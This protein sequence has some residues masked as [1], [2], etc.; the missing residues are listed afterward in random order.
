EIKKP[1]V[2]EEVKPKPEVEQP[3]YKSD[4]DV[5]TKGKPKAKET[6]VKKLSKTVKDEE[7]KIDIIPGEYKPKQ[8]ITFESI[9]TPKVTKHKETIVVHKTTPEE[10]PKE[11]DIP[12]KPTFEI[13]KHDKKVAKIIGPKPYQTTQI[14]F[15]STDTKPMQA[16][17]SQT[18]TQSTIT[19]QT[20]QIVH[21]E[22]RVTQSTFETRET[23]PQTAQFGVQQITFERKKPEEIK[24]E[25]VD[26]KL[27][28]VI[29]GEQPKTSQAEIS[30]FTQVQLQQATLEQRKPEEIKPEFVEYSLKKFTVDEH[31][32]T[33][34]AE[35]S[36]VPK[37]KPQKLISVEKVV[38]DQTHITT[39]KFGLKKTDKS[40][41]KP[42][43]PE[44]QPVTILKPK[45]ISVKTTTTTQVIE[46]TTIKKDEPKKVDEKI[47]IEVSSLKP[48]QE[49]TLESIEKPKVSSESKEIVYEDI[50]HTVKKVEVVKLQPSKFERKE[51][52]PERP[53]FAQIQL[54]P[55]RI[56]KRKPEEFKPEFVDYQLKGFTLEELPMPLQAQISELPKVQLQPAKIEKRKPEEI[57]PEF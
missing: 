13:I 14:E 56:E 15:S 34:R 6:I 5:V 52:V 22:T 54:Q 32:K 27:K 48:K 28:K 7:E 47:E 41:I 45:D 30:D 33:S 17:M 1:S 12:Q 49:I 16:A 29:F 26:Y 35:L 43:K 39:T 4:F 53:L 36:E 51:I 18:I 3:E 8:Q 37:L 24:P 31:P 21:K 46:T 9:E 57:K 42:K 23:K 55:A 38:E 11:E 20:S 50:S 44:E 2:T 10:L 40:F 19:S 25:F